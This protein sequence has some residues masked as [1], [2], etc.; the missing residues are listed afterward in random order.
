MIKIILFFISI[1]GLLHINSCSPVSVLASGGATT[2][3]V[4]EG[5]RSLGSVVDDATIKLNISSKFLQSDNNLFININS[6]IINGRVLLTGIVENQEIRINAVRTVW[7]A[8]GVKEVINEIE[9]GK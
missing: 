3:V 7:E 8:E 9:V 2:M 5:E 4:A 1:L 6:N